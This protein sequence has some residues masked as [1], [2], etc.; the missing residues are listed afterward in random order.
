MG[1]LP[2]CVIAESRLVGSAQ[3]DLDQWMYWPICLLVDGR[4]AI[5]WQFPLPVEQPSFE[6]GQRHWLL[7]GGFR[8]GSWGSTTALPLRYWQVACFVRN[9]PRRKLDK[10]HARDGNAG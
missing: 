4:H 2:Q 7:D 9:P 6:F 10:A 5:I 8:A 1:W 3:C